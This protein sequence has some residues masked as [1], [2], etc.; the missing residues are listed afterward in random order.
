MQ[1]A[2]SGAHIVGCML[3]GNSAVSAAAVAAAGARGGGGG[4]GVLGTLGRFGVT[5]AAGA[6]SQLQIPPPTVPPPLEA[7]TRLAAAAAVNYAR[8]SVTNVRQVADT[9]E[10]FAAEI[11]DAGLQEFS[12]TVVGPPHTGLTS[13]VIEIVSQIPEVVVL[14]CNQHRLAESLTE[15][16]KTHEIRCCCFMDHFPYSEQSECGA[17]LTMR[18]DL[19]AC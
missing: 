6:E 13:D 8:N 3:F 11:T 19:L 7:A 4:G 16:I 2:R 17:H 1:H 15:L 9:A 18:A 14:S 10:S 12:F 5:A